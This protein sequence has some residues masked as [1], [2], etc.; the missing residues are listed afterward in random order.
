VVY[1]RPKPRGFDPLEYL[2]RFFETV[3][4]DSTFYRPP[5]P[6]TAESWALRVAA[7]PRFRFTAKLWKRFTHERDTA[8]TKAEVD[9]TREAFEILGGKGVLGAVLM[10]FPWSFKQDE[11]NREWLRDLITAFNGLPLVLEVRHESWNTPEIYEELTEKK[12]GIVNIDQPLFHHSIRPSARATSALGYVRVHGRNY[13]D[14]FRKEAKSE[15]RYN[16]LYSANELRDWAER[17]QEL[18]GNPLVEDLYVVTN[19]HYL[20]KAPANALMLKSMVTHEITPSPP[21]LFAKY[22]SVLKDFAAP[23]SSERPPEQA[24]LF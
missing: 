6:K 18:A 2:S 10:Q 7:N 9:G 24:T 12:V 16:Y 20:G 1:P 8:W 17:T 5:T 14:W 23:S 21:L 15:Q 19:N 13:V 22:E 4:I 11:R 3:E